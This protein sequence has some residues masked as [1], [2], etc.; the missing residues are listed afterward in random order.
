M[1]KH[2]LCYSRLKA[3]SYL[4][5]TLV[6]IGLSSSLW[7]EEGKTCNIVTKGT[8]S[9]GSLQYTNVIYTTDCYIGTPEDKLIVV[10][11]ID[12]NGALQALRSSSDHLSPTPVI[13]S[14]RLGSVIGSSKK[15]AGVNTPTD[16]QK[17][18]Y[19]SDDLKV[20]PSMGYCIRILLDSGEYFYMH[21]YT[22]ASGI[23]ASGDFFTSPSNN[24]SGNWTAEGYTCG[25]QTLPEQKVKITEEGDVFT[26]IKSIGNNCMPAGYT[27]FRWDSNK[28]ICH[29]IEL[30]NLGDPATQSMNF[31][32]CTL[33]LTDQEHFKILLPDRN[34]YAISFQKDGLDSPIPGIELIG[35]WSSGYECNGQR[36]MKRITIVKNDAVLTATRQDGD[37]CM[38]DGYMQFY[39]D[40][41]T[42]VCQWVGTD[43]PDASF[44][45]F[46][47]CGLLLNPKE[48]WF[49]VFFPENK[50]RKEM[51]FR[52]IAGISY[53]P[54]KV[55]ENL[56]IQIPYAEYQMSPTQTRTIQGNLELVPTIDGELL[57]KM[58]SA[59][60]L[61]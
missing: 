27:T 49:S 20:A 42:D 25:D 34:N 60:F 55:A 17:A 24:I 31:T 28:D 44:D 39:Y 3:L 35:I 41:N 7:A 43:A 38:P 14:L 26:A 30:T 1:M 18:R 4:L 36:S 5:V 48:G 51:M 58:S 2:S 61:D 6:T 54:T 22:D 52:K 56:S 29:L 45:T 57:W 8:Y 46:Y 19:T 40:L 50:E 32:T 23:L 15:A 37:D 12:K 59:D 9:R 47:K 10:V 21:V 11:I 13:A 16:C 33:E 53:S